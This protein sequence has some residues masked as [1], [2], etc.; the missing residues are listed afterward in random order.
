M[1]N[2]KKLFKLQHFLKIIE[3]MNILLC[4]KTEYEFNSKTKTV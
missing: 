3:H 4:L 2:Y 1:G